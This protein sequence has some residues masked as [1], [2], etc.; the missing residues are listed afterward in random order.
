MRQK[1]QGKQDRTG[2]EALSPRP[3][4]R[5]AHTHTHTH[6]WMGEPEAEEA[7]SGTR[8]TLT[9]ETGSHLQIA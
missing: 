3:H 9:I 2:K 1:R 8:G 4:P 5:H 6:T 7:G